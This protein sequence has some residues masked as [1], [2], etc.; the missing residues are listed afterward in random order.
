MTIIRLIG[1]GAM[2]SLFACAPTEGRVT[3][4]TARVYFSDESPERDLVALPAR[5]SR[6]GDTERTTSPAAGGAFF[7]EYERVERDDALAAVIS[8]Q[9]IQATLHGPVDPR[10]GPIAEALNEVS[11]FRGFQL[12]HAGQSTAV[13]QRGKSIELEAQ[14]SHTPYLLSLEA[15]D[16]RGDSSL[17]LS[18][19]LTRHGSTLVSTNVV[20]RAGK[21]VIFGR[22]DPPGDKTA[23]SALMLAV[24]PA[25]IGL[26]SRLGSKAPDVDFDV[27]FR[28]EELARAEALVSLCPPSKESLRGGQYGPLRGGFINEIS[29]AT[30]CLAMHEYH[31]QY[32]QGRITEEQFVKASRELEGVLARSQLMSRPP[33]GKAARG[34]TSPRAAIKT[35]TPPPST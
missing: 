2:L 19:R 7:T 27:R 22:L 32:R 29:P 25:T 21:T 30:A 34:E 14:G 13:E 33:A 31:R 28:S 1:V 15:Q 18:V 11:R 9:L 17:E 12:I 3:T 20:V 24:K 10:L 16:I 6:E 23:S 8:F 4:D 26:R 5:R 35:R